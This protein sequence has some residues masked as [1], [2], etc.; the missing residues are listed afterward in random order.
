MGG[1]VKGDAPSLHFPTL[2][3]TCE[4]CRFYK[5]RQV[6]PALYVYYLLSNS[7]A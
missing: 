7:L 5:I 6:S 3:W 2:P 1:V 4:T